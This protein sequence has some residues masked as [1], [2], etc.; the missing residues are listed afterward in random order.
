LAI[1]EKIMPKRTGK[2]S[3]PG[4]GSVI[5]PLSLAAGRDL[6]AERHDADCRKDLWHDAVKHHV[7]I[8]VSHKFNVLY[9]MR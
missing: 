2:E 1:R 4:T 9:F 5:S 8:Q 3:L 7:K 6:P